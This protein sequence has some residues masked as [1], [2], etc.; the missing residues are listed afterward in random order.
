MKSPGC[1]HLYSVE[2][3]LSKKQ[4]DNFGDFFFSK[5]KRKKTIMFA[6][7]KMS[8]VTAQSEQISYLKL[9]ISNPKNK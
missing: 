4:L 2:V 6:I 1:H 5:K 7:S 9:Q 3:E 8:S